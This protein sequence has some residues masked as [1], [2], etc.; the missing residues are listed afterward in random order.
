[1][2]N[3]SDM[4]FAQV[5]QHLAQHGANQ[6]EGYFRHLAEAMPQIV[7]ITDAQGNVEY[8]N[9]YWYT[10]TGF[11]PGTYR[12]EDWIAAVHPDDLPIILAD[13]TIS[14][15]ADE[16]FEAEYRLRRSD[17]VYRWHLGRAVPVRDAEG[18]IVKRFGAAVDITEQKESAERL[19]YYAILVESIP[20][21]VITTDPDYR[22][23]GWNPGAERLY[24]WRADE[25]IGQIAPEML[26]AAVETGEQGKEAWEAAFARQEQWYGEFLKR[27]KD[28]AQIRVESTITHVKDAR[29]NILGVTAIDR[30]VTAERAI[31]ENVR[32]LAEAS[33]VLNSSLDY[34]T[35]LT[36][37]AQLGVP[38]IA[39]WCAVAM[40]TESG[41]IDQLAVAH[42]DPAKV[43]WAKEL[44]R[45]NPPDPDAPTGVPNVLR[46]GRSEFLPIITEEMLVAAGLD[47]EQMA[48]VRRIGFSSVMIVPLR[49]QE[50]TIGAMTFVSA[51]SGRHYTLADLAFAEEVANRAALAVENA[52]LYTEA[53]RAIAVRDEFLS[54]ASH[55]LK[56]PVTSLKMYTQVIQR[57]AERRGDTDLVDRLVKMDRQTDKLTTLINDLLSVSRIQ[58]GRLEYVDEAVD[59]NAVVH[60]TLDLIQPTTTRHQIIVEGAVAD[61]VWG[62]SERIGQI[63]ANFLTNAI[64]YSPQ[65]DRIIVRLESD[66]MCARISVQDFGIG[67]EAEHQPRLFE[68]FYR[69]SDPSEKTYPGLG[70]G[71]YI[72]S[73]IVRRHGG[74]IDVRST[75]GEGSTFT[76]TL[77]LM[78]AGRGTA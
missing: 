1:M 33:K 8:Y 4:A 34:R 21:A 66:D 46:T 15:D 72:A 35:T 75:R 64:K 77:P 56:T 2:E 26:Q 48:L 61:R 70:L 14:G 24:G 23:R 62:D 3:E 25:V 16:P 22:I 67:I 11:L 74:T 6:D 44:G 31:E 17:G 71:L 30:D 68:Q 63:V 36:T 41:G 55:E 38:E 43:E 53:Q 47:D 69:V 54:L 32:F 49:V 13:R 58:G 12:R 50:R 18:R 5:A 76:F 45:A 10:Y 52:R 73:E 57:Q 40:R 7:F 20:N 78:R 29:G 42:V 65:A 37:L 59:L 51:E 9:Q 39:D 27:R 28:G 19:R 60:E